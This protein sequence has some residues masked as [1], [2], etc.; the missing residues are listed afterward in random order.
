MICSSEFHARRANEEQRIA[1]AAIGP[2]K[3][4]A[5]LPFVIAIFVSIPLRLG[6]INL[7]LRG[8]DAVLFHGSEVIPFEIS[9]DTHTA[10]AYPLRFAFRRIIRIL[11]AFVDLRLSVRFSELLIARAEGAVAPAFH[12]KRPALRELASRFRALGAR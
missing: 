1:P 11:R 9:G 12:L 8:S 2:D 3:E 5:L 6:D 10:E 7:I 4:Q